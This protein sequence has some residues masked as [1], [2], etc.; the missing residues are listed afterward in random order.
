M[1]LHLCLISVTVEHRDLSCN[2]ERFNSNEKEKGYNKFNENNYKDYTI[3]K[4]KKVNLQSSILSLIG[5]FFTGQ[6][7]QTFQVAEYI[8]YSC[9]NLIFYYYKETKIYSNLN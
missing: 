3:I 9:L 8:V 7:F 1:I 6:D 4:A 2:V 5:R